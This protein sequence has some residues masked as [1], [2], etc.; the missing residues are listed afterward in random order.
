M[1]VLVALLFAGVAILA[2]SAGADEQQVARALTAGLELGLSL[3]A[4]LAAVHVVASEPAV[5]LQLTLRTR[6]RTT[7][8]RRLALLAGWTGAFALLWASALDLLGLWAVPGP[9][10]LGQLAWIA[11]LA[12]FVS[13]VTLV[14]LLFR[15]QAAA[16]AVLGLLW[17]F[18]NSGVGVAGFLQ[19]DWLRPFFLFATTHAP[20]AD[21]WLENRIV[22]ICLSLALLGVSLILMGRESL[23]M[24]GGE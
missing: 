21:F 4:G 2:A 17:V 19:S 7:L 12:W 23:S 22:V 15:S 3:A 5:D 10:A 20:G 13:A 6:Y 24:G 8:L 9:F 11:P 1:P 18:E 14:A 16:S